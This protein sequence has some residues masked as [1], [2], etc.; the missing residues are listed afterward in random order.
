MD[1]GWNVAEWRA[2]AEAAGTAFTTARLAVERAERDELRQLRGLRDHLRGANATLSVLTDYHLGCADRAAEGV[3]L[4]SL[5]A[6][7]S[8]DRWEA[9]VRQ[10]ATR[11]QA[12]EATRTDRRDAIT[13]D[14]EFVRRIESDPANAW[15][16]PEL[17]DSR[18]P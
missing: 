18:G 5:A 16:Q 17:V 1:P 3:R 7:E 11:Q 9:I 6:Q 8:F 12:Q 14:A 15:Q 2:R 4:A 13:D 10:G